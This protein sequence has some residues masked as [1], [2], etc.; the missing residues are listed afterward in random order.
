MSEIDN[1]E[2]LCLKKQKTLCL[3]LF[4][5][6][7]ISIGL[8]AIF[9]FTRKP[10][11]SHL[12]DANQYYN[13]ATGALL[14]SSEFTQGE[15]LKIQ[16]DF[17]DD[18]YQELLDRYDIVR[19]AGEGTEFE[20]AKRIMNH[21]SKKLSHE[22]NFIVN[23]PYKASDLLNYSLDKVVHGINCRAKAQIMN[24]LCLALGIY[25]RKLWIM[26]ASQYDDECHVVNEIYDTTYN[27][28]IFLDITTDQYCIDEAGMPLSAIEIRDKLARHEICVPI[29]VSE[30]KES[31]TSKDLKKLEKKHFD[32]IMYLS[33]NLFYF[34]Y[35]AY[36]GVGES[37]EVY[38]LLPHGITSDN[39]IS[40]E[41]C[42]RSPME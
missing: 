6:L 36:N 41:A 16:Y 25:S 40:L 22:S 3:V 13:L 10:F 38:L 7:I 34:K 15:D 1:E 20:K 17:F 39:M 32:R 24:E 14:V 23:I 31:Y 35:L 33:K 21:F 42:E 30:E 27:K 11:I 8:N 28:W 9:Y 26:P 5:L 29:K 19:I 4:I 2:E 37:D 12:E 18:Q